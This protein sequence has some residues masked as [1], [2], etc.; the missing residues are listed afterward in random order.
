MLDMILMY[1][2]EVPSLFYFMHHLLV[3]RKHPSVSHNV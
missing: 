2:Y 1:L 3:E